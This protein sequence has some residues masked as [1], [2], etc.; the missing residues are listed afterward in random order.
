MTLK[1]LEFAG[2]HPTLATTVSSTLAKNPEALPPILQS[3]AGGSF[4]P[5]SAAVTASPNVWSAIVQQVLA[6]LAE[7]PQVIGDLI[8]LVGELLP[9]A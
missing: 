3:L 8:S 5:L 4:A 2:K 9:K 1:L 6:Y 7:N